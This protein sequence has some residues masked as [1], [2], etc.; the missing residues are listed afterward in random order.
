MTRS[1]SSGAALIYRLFIVAV[2]QAMALVAHV[3]WIRIVVAAMALAM[4]AINIKDYFVFEAELD[5]TAVFRAQSRL[6][7]WLSPFGAAAG[8]SAVVAVLDRRVRRPI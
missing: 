6:S 7:R 8:L 2:V 4:G 5:C 3:P 1:G